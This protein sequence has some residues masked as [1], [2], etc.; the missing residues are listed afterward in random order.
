M[1]CFSHLRMSGPYGLPK[2]KSA[3]SSASAAFSSLL[4]IFRLVKS[5]ALDAAS[6]WVKWTT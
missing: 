6:A 5:C 4:Q 2:S 3:T 1:P